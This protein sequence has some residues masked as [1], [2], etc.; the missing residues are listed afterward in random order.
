[1]PDNNK[2]EDELALLNSAEPLEDKDWLDVARDATVF[3][4]K[5]LL[6]GLLDV[7]MVPVSLV[8]AGMSI[9]TGEDWFYRA[10]RIGR[11]LDE[12]LNLFGSGEPPPEDNP[13][14]DAVER[15]DQIAALAQRVE[16]EIRRELEA[17]KLSAG[18]RE[19]LSR[20]QQRLSGLGDDER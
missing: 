1:M 2:L 16:K 17:G 8:A 5:L 7:I 12:R 18:A 4:F 19:S 15:T 11:G 20:L 14:T 10:I 13:D 3:Q 9:V 6:D